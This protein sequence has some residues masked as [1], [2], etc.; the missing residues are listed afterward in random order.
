MGLEVP[1][2]LLQPPLATSWSRAHCACRRHGTMQGLYQG[3]VVRVHATVRLL[4]YAH[5]THTLGKTS[6][7][8]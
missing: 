1:R 3:T 4:P 5:L 7:H 2:E 6:R 8:S